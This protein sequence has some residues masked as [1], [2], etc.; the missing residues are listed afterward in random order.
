MDTIYD[1]SKITRSLKTDEK[2]IGF[3]GFSIDRN[4][5][6]GTEGVL[7]ISSYSRPDWSG[8]LT[9]TFIMETG[10]D[11][12]IKDDLIRHFSSINE[13]TLRPH[14]KEEFET[15]FRCPMDT[16]SKSSAWYFEEINIYSKALK[17]RER[18]I[19]EQHLIP[20]LEKMLSFHFEPVEWWD[21][22]PRKP[23]AAQSSTSKNKIEA[24]SL[25][26][27]LLKTDEKVI[28]FTGISI[29]HGNQPGKEGV[30]KISSYSR[31]DW[32]GYLTLTFI[33][34][35][36]GDSQIKDD[37]IRLFSSINENTLR[38]HFKEEFETIFRCPM[39]ALSKSPAWYFEEINIY[40][41]ALKGRERR[42]IEQHLIPSLEKM[43][44]FRFDPVEWWDQQPRKP[45][46]A[47]SSTSKNKIE[48]GS[49]KS[50]L[51]KWLRS[52]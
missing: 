16:L 5:Q 28:A 12:Q 19:V 6:P 37:L 14:F 13:N 11:S 27:E 4:N 24:G 26:S 36:E 29:D 51:M 20:A 42:I 40:F 45:D 7:K 10:G 8:Y 30:L 15:I 31:P 41:K 25:K 21:Q 2:V 44:P 22:Q 9:L 48:A 49:L 18:R 32:S 34:E 47:Q 38:P 46:V 52:F 3:T 50:A 35:T 33:M 23:D 43:L 17:G 1:L 39:D